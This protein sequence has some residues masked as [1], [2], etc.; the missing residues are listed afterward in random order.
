[1]THLQKKRRQG[2]EKN[3][4]F[5][6]FLKSVSR[7]SSREEEMALQYGRLFPPT[8]GAATI[9]LSVSGPQP[10][11]TS[12][13]RKGTFICLRGGR[14]KDKTNGDKRQK[15]GERRDAHEPLLDEGRTENSMKSSKNAAVFFFLPSRQ[16]HTDFFFFF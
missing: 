16:G 10:F 11:P 6:L 9:M 14:Q 5:F 7:T 4:F 12:H 15:N 13:P 8:N 3:K 1:M 2:R